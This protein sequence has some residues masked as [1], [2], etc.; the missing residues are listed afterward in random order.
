MK[1]QRR[2]CLGFCLGLTALFVIYGRPYGSPEHDYH[3]KQ[4]CCRQHLIH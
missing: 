4:R 3:E 2:F 1:T